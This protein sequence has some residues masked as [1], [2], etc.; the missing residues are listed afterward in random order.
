MKFNYEGKITESYVLPMETTRFK[1]QPEGSKNISFIKTNP[2]MGTI[3]FRP[4][5]TKEYPIWNPEAVKGQI[6]QMGNL[7]P[8]QIYYY[9]TTRPPYKFYPVPKYWSGEGWIYVDGQVQ[10]FDKK[11]LD[12]GFFQSVYMQMVGDP[13]QKSKNPKFQKKVKGV[14]GTERLEVTH[15]VGEEFNEQM[16]KSFSGFQRAGGAFVNW[17]MNA[18]SAIPVQAFPVNTNAET[19]AGAMDRAIRGI[20]IA[21]E[22]PAILANLPQQSNSLGSDGNAIKAAIDLMQSRVA[23]K[24]NLLENFYNNILLANRVERTK[25]Q[26]KIKNYVPVHTQISVD[27]KFWDVMDDKQKEQFVVEN[28]PGDWKNAKNNPDE[29]NADTPDS[30]KA[31]SLLYGSLG[32]AAGLLAIQQAVTSEATTYESAIAMLTIIYRFNPEQARALLGKKPVAAET[33]APDQ[34]QLDE[35]GQPIPPPTK[36]QVDEVLKNMKVSEIKRI[37]SI[38]KQLEKG[39]LT[40]AQARQLLSGYGLSQEQIAEW[41]TPSV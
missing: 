4:D 20:T 9:G 41:I 37:K 10:V 38:V 14:D 24:Q 6:E 35:Q 29:N 1:K 39:D 25:A 27:D 18:Q 28:I 22:V 16:A 26:V 33:V 21:T 40:D 8:G 15:T 34:I 19:V 36:P 7:F 11:N 5:Q 3:D 13:N 17:V 31:Q 2:Y 30:I 32:G 12:N 23:A